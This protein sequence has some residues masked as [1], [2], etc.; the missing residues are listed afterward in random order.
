MTT[1]IKN[2]TA[3]WSDWT[4]KF[5]TVLLFIFGIFALYLFGSIVQDLIIALILAFILFYPSRSL[6]RW[7][8]LPYGVSVGIVFIC[9]LGIITYLFASFLPPLTGKISEISVDIQQGVEKFI[10]D[11]RDYDPSNSNA[12]VKASG[13]SINTNFI[14]EPLSKLV[15]GEDVNIQ[16]ITDV[17][18]SVV[19]AS[20]NFLKEIPN[21]LSKILIIHFL[22]ILIL[23][24]IPRIYKFLK[25]SISDEYRREYG[26]LMK[27]ASSVPNFF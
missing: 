14:L 10:V 13:Y 20:L 26:I 5:A 1:K 18:P 15:K 12:N 21:I 25:G 17:I 7:A 6:T 11:L 9:Y 2:Y 23:L 19:N 27:K 8:R 3:E 16:Q 4:K 22:A 24:D